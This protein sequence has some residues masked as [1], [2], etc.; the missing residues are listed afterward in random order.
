M[1]ATVS[2]SILIHKIAEILILFLLDCAYAVHYK[3]VNHVKRICAHLLVTFK[4]T[5]IDKICPEIGISDQ[6]YKCAECSITLNSRKFRVYT[7]Y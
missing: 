1:F 5:M 4:K 6:G 2:C 7:L 3:C